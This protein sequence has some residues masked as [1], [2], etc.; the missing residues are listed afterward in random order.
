M[1][2]VLLVGLGKIGMG[3][4]LDSTSD[5]I[6]MTHAKAITLHPEFEIV[7]AVDPDLGLRKKF[8]KSY[9]RPAYKSIEEATKMHTFFDLVIVAAPTEQHKGIIIQLLTE[10][11]PKVILCEKPLSY[12]NQE[13]KDIVEMCNSENVKLF[14]NYM[15]RS[16]PAVIEI[17]NLIANGVMS[18]PI[19]GVAWYSKGFIHNG[20]H[21]FNLIEFWL[22]KYLSSKIIN[23]GRSIGESDREP[24]VC[25]KFERGEVTFI[26]LWEE[27]FSHY[28]IELLS[29]SGR[30]N[31][32][33]GGEDVYLQKVRKNPI[34]QGYRH[35]SPDIIK[36]KNDMNHYQL[37]VLNQIYNVLNEKE[38]SLCSGI[39]GMQTITNMQNILMGKD[40]NG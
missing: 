12:S 5:N 34:V 2:N 11:I 30:V 6:I 38:Y 31:Y 21:F 4:D 37:N 1:I 9:Q 7:A 39:E 26:A 3:Y 16:D 29:P 18:E 15:R 10:F 13:A 23:Y 35:L 32:S 25:V 27:H 36:I 14:V 28:T 22:G 17:K 8:V 19:K 20:S 33:R 24:D 40:E